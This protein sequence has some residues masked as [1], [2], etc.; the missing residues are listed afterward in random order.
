MKNVWNKGLK[1]VQV[2]WNKGLVGYLKGKSG[3]NRGLTKEDHLG[4]RSQSEKIRGKPSWN[5]GLKGE[6]S[7]AFGH[8][9]SSETRGKIS[10]SNS[11]E[12]NPMFGK[13]SPM[14][15]KH[16][17]DESKNKNREKHLGKKVMSDVEKGKKSQEL[18]ERWKNPDYRKTMLECD[19][20][21]GSSDRNKKISESKKLQWQD[22]EWKEKVLKKVFV[23]NEIK[24]NKTEIFTDG[25]VQI[26]RPTDFIY[27]GAGKIFIAGKV[28]DWFNVNGRKQVIELFG[29]YWHGESRTGR[30]KEQEEVFL[31][32]HYAKYGYDCLVIWEN[33]L[34][35]PDEVIQKI[36]NF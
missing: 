13:I 15:N 32:S 3:W 6:L 5:K 11:G 20:N 2:A 28:P 8:V 14:R 12:N 23:S 4:I 10:V 17:S 33:E 34:K 9:V 35:S 19:K 31:K 21:W 16:H 25:L 27:S 1:G 30:T 24:P 18:K 29:N 26:A 22:I 36:K 7:H